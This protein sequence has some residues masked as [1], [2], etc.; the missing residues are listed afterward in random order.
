[1]RHCAMIKRAIGLLDKVARPRL[2]F[3]DQI[4]SDGQPAD[5]PYRSSRSSPRCVSF[6]ITVA[7]LLERRSRT[8]R[9]PKFDRRNTSESGVAWHQS[10]S[11]IRGPGQIA[12]AINRANCR[13]RPDVFASL[14]G[15]LA[16]LSTSIRVLQDDLG[17]DCRSILFVTSLLQNSLSCESAF[18][19][20][21][22][23]RPLAAWDRAHSPE[24]HVLSQNTA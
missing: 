12:H 10:Q 22:S 19:C 16:P 4:R 21:S 20:L 14:N 17:L 23:E 3:G 13:S 11:L 8:K 7:A 6:A 2:M 24:Y 15:V 18:Q 5:A 1:M 9:R